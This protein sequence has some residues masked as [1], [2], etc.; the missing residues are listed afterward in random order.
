MWALG[1]A[2]RDARITFFA[3]PQTPAGMNWDDLFFGQLAG[4]PG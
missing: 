4:D 2:L 1:N 3:A